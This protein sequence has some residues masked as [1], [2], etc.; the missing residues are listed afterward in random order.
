MVK[1]IISYLFAILL[2]I[3]ISTLALV[4]DSEEQKI[5]SQNTKY[6]KTIEYIESNNLLYS[7]KKPLVE[8]IEIT[9]EE[10]ETEENTIITNQSTIINTSYKRMT[11]TISKNGNGYRYSNEV[12]W[13]KTPVTRSYD[14]I[15]IGFNKN[16][17]VKSN[18]SFKLEY[19]NNSGNIVT[20]TTNYLQKFTTGVGTV[21][22]MPSGDVTNITVTLSFDV[23]KNTTETLYAQDI[24]GDYAHATSIISLANAKK[25]TVNDAG[26][27]LNGTSSYYDEISTANVTYV[28]TW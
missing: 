16:V 14:I 15:A 9:K 1:K 7:T 17:K 6:Y 11:S 4:Q 26:I 13:K 8:T 5:V 21:F 3:P 28:G 27:V 19:T 12:F 22:E 2:I 25:F 18:V 24:Y 23:E 10:F 20:S